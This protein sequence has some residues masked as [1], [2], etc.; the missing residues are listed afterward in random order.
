MRP[1]A[2]NRN[3]WVADFSLQRKRM[4]EEQIAARGVRDKNVLRAMEK[5]HRH[6]FVP[7]DLRGRA[8]SDS[9]LP[10]GAGQTISQPYIVACMIEALAIKPGDK[11]LEIG[12][13]SGYAAAVLAELADE[14]YAIECIS[15]LA[16]MATW[17][18]QAAGY[19]NVHM[20]HADGTKGWSE[21]A[22]FDA[23]LVSAGA[24]GVPES[25]KTQ[26]APGGRMVIPI[27]TSMM[28][29]KLVCVT[30]Q[31]DG[32]FAQHDLTD[33]RFVPLVGE[34]GWRPDGV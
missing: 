16:E 23:I 29:Q 5:V 11:A 9:P 1:A 17:N 4:V 22:P 12:A 33:V 28:Y 13:G 24:P 8:Y 26:L 32:S 6:K 2:I 19:T 10:I 3:S 30:R 27:G 34:E 18:L 25:L 15:A 31:K 7:A 20:L 14:V 21:H